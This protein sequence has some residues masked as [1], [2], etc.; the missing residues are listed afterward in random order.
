MK[1]II[2]IFIVASVAITTPIIINMNSDKEV[3]R[4]INSPS[5]N[6][7]STDWFE[8]NLGINISKEYIAFKTDNYVNPL[9]KSAKDTLN[10][11]YWLGDFKI[12]D[13]TNHEQF[14]TIDM[15]TE[16][17]NRFLFITSDYFVITSYMEP[18]ED[19]GL[20]YGSS[21]LYIPKDNE[22]KELDSI[23]VYG[24]NNFKLLGYL[25][26]TELNEPQFI[27]NG[28]YDVITKNF[29]VKNM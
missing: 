15:S 24:I 9:R 13:I 5:S 22:L 4:E 7:E 23:I 25:E 16:F 14:T 12:V 18:E 27:E 17:R 1:T 29:V 10:F 28:Y 2:T 26:H 11:E 3:N 20:T 21:L 6:E 19:T 8:E